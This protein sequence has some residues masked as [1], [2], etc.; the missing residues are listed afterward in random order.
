MSVKIRLMRVGTKKR[1][2]Y[3]IIAIDTRKKRDGAY[4]EKLGVYHPLKKDEDEIIV[5]E[6]RIKDWLSKGAKPSHTVKILLNKKGIQ[7]T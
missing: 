3:R 6:A 5:E 4:L 2:Y 1:P 7:L